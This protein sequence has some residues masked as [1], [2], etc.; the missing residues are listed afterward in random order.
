MSSSHDT[1]D[2]RTDVSAPR[3]EG[4]ACFALRVRR[5]DGVLC[6]FNMGRPTPQ[7]PDRCEAFLRAVADKLAS[8]GL[9]PPAADTRL[10]IED[11]DGYLLAYTEMQSGKEHPTFAL[12]SSAGDLLTIWPTAGRAGGVKVEH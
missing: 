10:D 6:L 5:R 4:D 3:P 2:G 12:Y 7:H 9:D 8:H 1:R 11:Q